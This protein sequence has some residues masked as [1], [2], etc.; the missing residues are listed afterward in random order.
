MKNGTAIRRKASKWRKGKFNVT[1]A[2]SPQ[3][4]NDK[5]NGKS[6]WACLLGVV[7][8]AGCVHSH[9]SCHLSTGFHLSNGAAMNYQVAQ[10]P[11]LDANNKPI[12]VT[13][14]K[15]NP[16]KNPDGTIQYRM[17]DATPITPPT[18]F[19]VVAAL[20]TE[21]GTR[22]PGE[23]APDPVFQNHMPLTVTETE[24]VAYSGKAPVVCSIT[25]LAMQK[26]GAYIF[27]KVIRP[28]LMR[29]Q[30]DPNAAPKNQFF[31]DGQVFE[32]DVKDKSWVKYR[33]GDAA[34]VNHMNNDYTACG[35]LLIL[36]DHAWRTRSD[37]SVVESGGAITFTVRKDSESARTFA[38]YPTLTLRNKLPVHLLAMETQDVA[39]P[40]NPIRR[41]AFTYDSPSIIDKDF[42]K[43][44]VVSKEIPN[45]L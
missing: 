13:D 22:P 37:F 34:F 6:H 45:P 33:C 41:T 31:K 38:G 16:L 29:D 4:M 15:G 43:P 39:N 12:P 1:F 44:T 25:Q 20:A 18:I 23:L 26:N 5:P 9:E 21:L 11:Q 24:F 2:N 7:F 42:R 3:L 28:D 8:L 17:T 40:N 35:L 32:Q 30:S 14:A 36:A 10:V 27:C 19:D